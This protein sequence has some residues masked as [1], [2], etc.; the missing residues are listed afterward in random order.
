[1]SREIKNR[2]LSS[3]IA[4]K[5][6]QEILDGTHASGAQ[7][8]QDALAAAFG[9][10]RIPLREAFF[11]LEAEGLLQII[12]HKGAIVTALSPLEINDIFDLR[13]V[14]EP[15][16]LTH[17]IPHLTNQDFDALMVIQSQFSDA[18]ESKD[19][20]VWGALNAQLHMTLYSRSQLTQTASIVAALLQKSDRYTRVQLSS[21]AA[22]KRAE[23]EHAELIDLC[24]KRETKTACDLLWQH[25][26]TVRTDLLEL[27]KCAGQT[28][29]KV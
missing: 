14:L 13:A 24:K 3:V 6:R 28:K 1:M 9:V 26:E 8:R 5:L 21:A 20:R 7:L 29:A 2:T 18:I 12:P 27:L 23:S 22:M 16:L 19:L 10:S 17:S 15:R 4:E 11:Q 25:I